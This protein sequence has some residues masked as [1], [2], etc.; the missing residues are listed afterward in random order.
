V[1]TEARLDN[2]LD[3]EER[4]S[5]LSCFRLSYFRFEP[6]QSLAKSLD[7][8][9]LVA[10]TCDKRDRDLQLDLGN[11]RAEHMRRRAA[12]YHRHHSSLRPPTRSI[13]RQLVCNA[14][15]LARM[16]KMVN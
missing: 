16:A 3:V 11:C 10:G 1:K 13:R 2:A 7:L 9:A 4:V 6:R 5:G 8:N 14:R 15:R 12:V